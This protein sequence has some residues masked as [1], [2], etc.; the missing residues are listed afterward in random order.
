[1]ITSAASMDGHVRAISADILEFY[2]RVL[3]SQSARAEGDRT[4]PTSDTVLPV[5]S[6]N[7]AIRLSWAVASRRTVRGFRCRLSVI[8]QPRRWMDTS[9]RSPIG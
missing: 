3:V 7:R 2:A 4:A 5:S 8:R 1:V 9:R 6:G